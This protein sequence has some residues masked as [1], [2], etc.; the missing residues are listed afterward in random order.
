MDNYKEDLSM[1]LSF[2]YRALPFFYLEKI[3]GS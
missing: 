2:T 1:D 3:F